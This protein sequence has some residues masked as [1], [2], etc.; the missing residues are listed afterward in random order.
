MTLLL[1]AHGYQKL[2][3]FDTFSSVTIDLQLQ[4]FQLNL[5]TCKTNRKKYVLLVAN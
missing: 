1:I 2:I 5:I 3:Q 4:E